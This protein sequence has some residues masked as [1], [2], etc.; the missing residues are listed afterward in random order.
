MFIL[1]MGSK[2]GIS[3]DLCYFCLFIFFFLTELLQYS[4]HNLDAF[5]HDQ[6]VDEVFLVGV[7]FKLKIRLVF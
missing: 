3:F 7:F 6:R 1:I 5:I 4:H 2:M